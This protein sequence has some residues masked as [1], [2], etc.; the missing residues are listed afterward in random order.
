MTRSELVK[1]IDAVK[2]EYL[3][4]KWSRV[5]TYRSR[6]DQLPE[7]AKE[8]SH[9]KSALDYI[10]NHH[11][12]AIWTLST[13]NI[14]AWSR[15]CTRW[16]LS[17]VLITRRGDYRNSLGFVNWDTL[18][19][20]P[21]PSRKSASRNVLRSAGVRKTERLGSL[22]FSPSLTFGFVIANFEGLG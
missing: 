19:C 1:R 21:N 20:C 3:N 11:D 4:V 14:P 15:P 12:F 17:R 9:L 2:K 6:K 22:V 16:S 10:D 13:T 7:L 18:K 8:L 5:K